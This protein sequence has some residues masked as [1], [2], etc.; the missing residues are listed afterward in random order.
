[1]RFLEKV[2]PYR[3]KGKWCLPASGKGEDRKYSMGIEFQMG[4]TKNSGDEGDDSFAV[5]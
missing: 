2:N 1:M 4:K 3:C 5:I